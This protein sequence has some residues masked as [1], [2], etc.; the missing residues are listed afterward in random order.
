RSPLTH[1]L[2][3]KA[4]PPLLLAH[5]GDRGP[6]GHAG[7]VLVPQKFNISAE[8][9]NRDLPAG[10]VT[11]VEAEQFRPETDRKR[12]DSHAAPAPDQEMAELVE[13][14]HNAEYEQNWQARPAS[15]EILH[16]IHGQYVPRSAPAPA[17]GVK[18]SK[19]P[20]RQFRARAPL[21]T[22]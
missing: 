9:N 2:I 21:P 5:L 1:R 7:G 11:V 18:F 8:W 12:Q 4:F 20:L 15:N 3:D 16:K 17:N 10:P 13:E 19:M 14:H 22:I 6:V